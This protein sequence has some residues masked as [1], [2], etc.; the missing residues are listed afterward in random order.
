MAITYT[1]V[2]G[3]SFVNAG[4]DDTWLDYDI[5]TNHGIPKGSIAEII[6]E[7][8]SATGHTDAGVREDGSGIGRIYRSY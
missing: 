3:E 1:E 8:K 7:H 2:W 4:A 5:F 6:I